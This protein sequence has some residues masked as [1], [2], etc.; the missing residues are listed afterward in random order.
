[1]RPSTEEEQAIQEI[2]RA[3]VGSLLTMFPPELVT[4]FIAAPSTAVTFT[5]E[6]AFVQ[7]PGP[8]AGR[9]LDLS[10]GG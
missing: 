7:T 5:V 9:P 1:M 2:L 3:K 6:E 10:A 8:G 4:G